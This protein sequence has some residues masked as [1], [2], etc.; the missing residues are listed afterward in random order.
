MNPLLYLIGG[1]VLFAAWQNADTLLGAAGLN[2]GG[3]YRWYDIPQGTGTKRINNDSAVLAANG[4]VEVLDSL[5]VYRIVTTTQYAK[6][7]DMIREY[8]NLGKSSTDLNAFAAFAA[9]HANDF[10]TLLKNILDK[11]NPNTSLLLPTNAQTAPPQ[12]EDFNIDKALK[13]LEV[14]TK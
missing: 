1:G 12:K 7:T 5:G 3:R 8:K 13:K 11:N 2:N 10:G 14:Q 4:Y 6:Y 9:A